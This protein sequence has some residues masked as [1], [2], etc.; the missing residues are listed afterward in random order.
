MY[1]HIALF[2]LKESAEGHTKE[3]NIQQIL[4]NIQHMKETISQIKNITAGPYYEVQSIPMIAYDLAIW[5]ELET[6]E[7]YQGY[8]QHPVHQEAAH[9]AAQVSDKVAAITYKNVLT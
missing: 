4:T 7:D 9:F 6:L 5:V 8:I 3:E 2:T 1:T